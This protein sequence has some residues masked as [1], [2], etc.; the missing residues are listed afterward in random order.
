[1][2]LVKW[3]FATPQMLQ[4]MLSIFLWLAHCKRR[5]CP[6][7]R[8]GTV[9]ISEGCRWGADISMCVLLNANGPALWLSPLP[10]LKASG[11]SGGAVCFRYP[12]PCLPQDIYAAHQ[13][14]EGPARTSTWLVVETIWR[15]TTD[16]YLPVI[17]FSISGWLPIPGGKGWGNVRPSHL[18]S[19]HLTS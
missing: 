11:P 5:I 12:R 4:R 19:H 3:G 6:L 2:C 1:M 10:E 13:Q 8:N 14:E 7:E 16:Y 9:A 18:P 15:P 17:F